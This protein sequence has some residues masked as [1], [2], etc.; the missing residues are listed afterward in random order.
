MGS[1][2]NRIIAMPPIL[3]KRKL[4]GRKKCNF[5]HLFVK[6]VKVANFSDIDKQTLMVNSEIIVIGIY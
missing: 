2:K 5:L 6:I 1:A 3:R 4:I